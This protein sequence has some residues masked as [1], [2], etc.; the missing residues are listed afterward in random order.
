MNEIYKYLLQNINKFERYDDKYYRILQFYRG[1]LVKLGDM[2]E[3]KNI[4]KT[5]NYK[6]VK[7]LKKVIL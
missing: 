5:G 1:R 4:C 6:I 7:G 2:K 3:L